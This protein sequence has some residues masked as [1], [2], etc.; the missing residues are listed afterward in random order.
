MVQRNDCDYFKPSDVDQFYY[1]ELKEAIENGVNVK[2]ISV[3]WTDNGSCIFN[4]FI[5]VII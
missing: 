1:K 5:P 4:G 3:N 2:A